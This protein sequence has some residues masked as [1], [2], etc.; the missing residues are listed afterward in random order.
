MQGIL[1]ELIALLTGELKHPQMQDD[2]A[3]GKVDI[4]VSTRV[5]GF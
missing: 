2:E 4:F 3:A 5:S 1:D